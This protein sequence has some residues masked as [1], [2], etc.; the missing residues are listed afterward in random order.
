MRLRKKLSNK[1]CILFQRIYIREHII[2]WRSGV[3][4]HLC[5]ANVMCDLF[6]CIIL[7]IT[8]IL[9]DR[10]WL[11]HWI[12]SELRVWANC[13]RPYWTTAIAENTTSGRTDFG[14]H[15]LN[16]NLHSFKYHYCGPTCVFIEGVSRC[17]LYLGRMPTC[18]VTIEQQ[19]PAQTTMASIYC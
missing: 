13:I 19:R 5:M 8:K 16:S 2:A 4:Y 9:Y 15:S 3:A 18:V 17:G 10:F 6:I 11:Q 12:V 7:I 14:D 1:L